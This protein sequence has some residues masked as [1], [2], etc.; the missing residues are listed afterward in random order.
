MK[1]E[2]REK[3]EFT[4]IV[5]VFSFLSLLIDDVHQDRGKGEEGIYTTLCMCLVF[6]LLTDDVCQDRGKGEEGIYT[7]LYLHL[8]IFLDILVEIEEREKKEST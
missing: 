3:K 7:T 1:I 5:Y 6:C 8:V 2:R 4:H